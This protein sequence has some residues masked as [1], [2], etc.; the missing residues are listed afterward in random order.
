MPHKGLPRCPECRSVNG[1]PLTVSA[2]SA[3]IR[4]LD[5]DH[6][7]RTTSKSG[8]RKMREIIGIRERIEAKRRVPQIFD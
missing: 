5:C 6:E 3:T 7:M 1:T 2:G 4:C 8:V